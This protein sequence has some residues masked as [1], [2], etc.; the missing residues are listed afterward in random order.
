MKLISPLKLFLKK[1][2]NISIF[3]TAFHAEETVLDSK[4]SRSE[5]AVTSSEK[6]A[7]C[8]VTTDRLALPCNSSCRK[9][10]KEG[11]RDTV[12]GAVLGRKWPDRGEQSAGITLARYDFSFEIQLEWPVGSAAVANACHLNV[13]RDIVPEHGAWREHTPVR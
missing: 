3:Q 6:E 5:I 12:P 8:T 11:S 10:D 2:R 1:K 7:D 13:S 4:R 9:R